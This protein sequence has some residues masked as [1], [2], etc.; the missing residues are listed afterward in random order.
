MSA[1]FAPIRS[2]S[3]ATFATCASPSTTAP[4]EGSCFVLAPFDP[5]IL[6]RPGDQVAAVALIKEPVECTTA[7]EPSRSFVKPFDNSIGPGSAA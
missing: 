2:S 1:D 4:E 3:D 5:F 6:P 7:H